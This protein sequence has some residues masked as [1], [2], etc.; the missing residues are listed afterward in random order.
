MLTLLLSPQDFRPLQPQ[1]RQDVLPGQGPRSQPNRDREL[2]THLP[3]ATWLR[4]HPVSHRQ[5]LMSQACLEHQGLAL[6]RSKGA[7]LQLLQQPTPTMMMPSVM[8]LG[9]EMKRMA[10]FTGS[11]LIWLPEDL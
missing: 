5:P 8:I 2:E 6:F 9:P 4:P 3:T 11:S 10:E 7:T 1:P